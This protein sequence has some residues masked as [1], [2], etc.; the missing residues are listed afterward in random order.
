[1]PPIESL[2]AKPR[3]VRAHYA[4]N[5]AKYHEPQVVRS[6]IDRSRELRFDN[7]AEMLHLAHLATVIAPHCK[8]EEREHLDLLGEAWVYLASALKVRGVLRVSEVAFQKAKQFL[9]ETERPDLH[10]SYLECFAALRLRQVRLADARSTLVEALV[11]R[12][13]M[14]EA[15]AIAST[16]NQVALLEWESGQYVTALRHLTRANRL[17][18]WDKDPR[19]CLISRH[20]SILVL[21]SMGRPAIALDLYERLQ[22]V[23]ATAGDRMLRLR[24]EWLFAKVAASF[25]RAD[26]DETAERAFRATAQVAIELELPYESA[27]VLFEMGSFF[28]SRGRWHRLEMVVIE[29]L[30]LLDYLGIGRDAAVARVLL[31]AARQRRRSVNLLSRAGLLINR[32]AF[33]AAA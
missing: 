26:T 12:E 21:T 22:P 33:S 13:Q 1:M 19:M 27:K 20:N 16:L 17:I 32:H 29:S 24:G 14:G 10:A 4:A 9:A 3:Q 11:I 8:G 6:L 7:P 5:V 15:G 30:N 18:P 31:L 2:L 25:G 28:A 23:Y